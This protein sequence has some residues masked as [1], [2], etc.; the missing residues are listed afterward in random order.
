[1][2]PNPPHPPVEP[3][4]STDDEP[5]TAAAAGAT[6]TGSP[7]LLPAGVFLALVA[8][9]PVVNYL[10]W[11]PK[12]AFVPLIVAGGLPLLVSLARQGD[13]AAATGL[14]FGAISAVSAA[15][16]ENHTTS[17]FGLYGWGTGLIFVIALPAAWAIGRH[18]TERATRRRLELAVLTAAGLNV[19]I[20]IAQSLFNLGWAKLPLADDRATG[21]LGSPVSLS[22]L[23]AGAV[24]LAA[25]RFH[26]TW[27]GAMW[28]LALGVGLQLCGSRL[29]LVGAFVVTLAALRRRPRLAVVFAV[30]L[31]VG[32]AIGGPVS[33]VRGGI[34]GT[35]RLQADTATGGGARLE[36]WRTG[37]EAFA[38]RPVLGSGPGTYGAA[39]GHL[40]TPELARAEG[41]DRLFADAHNLVVEYAVTTGALGLTAAG[42]FAAL[43]LRRVRD[44]PMAWLAAGLGLVHLAQPQHVTLTP[45][46][47]LALGAAASEVTVLPSRAVRVATA[48]LAV[49]AVACVALLLYGDHLLHESD[50]DFTQDQAATALRILPRWSEPASLQARNVLY[51]AII[52]R[53]RAKFEASREWRAEATR[54]QPTDPSAWGKL[55]DMDI[56]LA[57]PELA[58]IHFQRGLQANPVS[59][60]LRL[61]LAETLLSLNRPAE[62]LVVLEEAGALGP[63]ARTLAAIAVLTEEAAG[64][65]RRPITSP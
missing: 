14:A 11:S 5:S 33:S 12:A 6:T 7:S 17:V 47:F 55:A 63:D 15:L 35:Q 24:G 23:L 32:I 51:E 28:A 36:N 18:S 59:V 44:T 1:M 8:F 41:P 56:R 16:S 45:L 49:P 48:A 46:M 43:V 4:V 21:L 39:T 65:A 37:A 50:L 22:A 10:F 20:A 57:Q 31:A 3:L 13:R 54:R 60:S 61:G 52:T 25:S 40:R 19:A 27:R 29:A 42:L 64:L 9:S 58:L 26:G 34:S 38:D 53:S 2:P 30:A 62:A